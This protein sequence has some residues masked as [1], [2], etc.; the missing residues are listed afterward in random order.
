[1]G[2]SQSLDEPLLASAPRGATIASCAI[3]LAST[4]LGTGMLSLPAAFVLAGFGAGT[5]LCIFTALLTVASLH[6]LVTCANR[7]GGVKSD[8]YTVCEAALP[9]SGRVVDVAV[10][11]NCTG[12]AVSYL[13]VAAD[14]FTATFGVPRVAV[15]LASLVV[16]APPSLFRTMDTLKATSTIAVVC[17]LAIVALVV[18]MGFGPS[19][20]LEPCPGKDEVPHGHCQ[21]H[22]EPVTRDG[23][24]VFCAIPFFVNAFTCQQNAFIAVGE[25][26]R[27]TPARQ[28]AVVV[29]APV[30]ALALYITVAVCGYLTFGDTTPSNIITAYPSS[31][32]VVAARCVLGLVVL[33]NYP[34]QAFPTRAS[35]ASLLDSW[36]GA[37]APADDG[38]GDGALFTRSARDVRIALAF[39]AATGAVALFVTE[40]GAIVSLVGS[41]ASALIGLVTPAVAHLLLAR[42]E[43]GGATPWASPLSGASLV[44]LAVGAA[45]LP[46]HLFCA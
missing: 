46:S 26:A 31:P 29:A 4:C 21:G 34:L 35:V 30:L 10:V 2:R 32:P 15:V 43:A 13:I 28:T 18:L 41:T 19:P 38:D 22:V 23:L 11:V 1:M 37:A 24:H 40:L 42:R 5:A 36:G 17:M 7:L 3:N 44:L 25:L 9:G 8:F 39:V 20:W 6:L 12:T 16:T 27:P 14:C 45:V 33:C